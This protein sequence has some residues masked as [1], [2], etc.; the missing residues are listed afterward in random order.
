MRNAITGVPFLP[1]CRLALPLAN[2]NER[3]RLNIA[4]IAGM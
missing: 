4:T 2:I 1:W 3:E